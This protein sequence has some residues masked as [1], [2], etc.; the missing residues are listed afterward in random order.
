VLSKADLV[1]PEEADLAATVWRER[2]AA[3][4]PAR[5][6]WEEPVERSPVI[7]TSSATGQGL[8]EL[9]VELLRR[10]PAL[11]PGDAL[12]GVDDG[13]AMAEH[14]VFRP[15]AARRRETFE[16]EQVEGGPWRVS[17]DAIERLIARHDL[18]NEDAL[19]HVEHR[20]QRMGVIRALEAKGFE[21]G[22]DVEIGG[23]IFEL[24]PG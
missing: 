3:D 7:V 18:D 13:A 22:D 15:A 12:P 2:F 8:D 24:D 5:E 21:P 4:A 14:R 19:M 11:D 16:V 20:L 6:A 10:V 23:V 9:R 17:G 1:A